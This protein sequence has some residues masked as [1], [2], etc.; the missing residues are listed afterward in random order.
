MAVVGFTQLSAYA[1]MEARWVSFNANLEGFCRAPIDGSSDPILF[2]KW[3]DLDLIY[4]YNDFV[5][6]SGQCGER[7][8]EISDSS[9]DKYALS[10]CQ[11]EKFTRVSF[12]AKSLES[13]KYMEF[14]NAK[15]TSNDTEIEGAFLYKLSPVRTKIFTHGTCLGF[16]QTPTYPI[17]KTR[18]SVDWSNIS[19]CKDYIRVYLMNLKNL[20]S[21]YSVWHFRLCILQLSILCIQYYKLPAETKQE[22][23]LRAENERTKWLSEAYK[24]TLE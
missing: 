15:K 19:T 4:Q 2:S 6:D 24:S 3:R 20:F 1:V 11:Q 12:V 18:S 17:Y 9:I 10:A 13:I 16:C 22:E 21:V 7:I 14:K 5:I 8:N 23:I